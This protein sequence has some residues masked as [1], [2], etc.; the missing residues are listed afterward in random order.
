[1]EEREWG[2][3]DHQDLRGRDA[4]ETESWA[5][6]KK[7]QP[8]VL[9]AP[10]VEA[11]GSNSRAAKTKVEITERLREVKEKKK[12]REERAGTSRF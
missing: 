7:K 12:E 5:T 9:R 4:R 2:G 6:Q 10:Q 3:R 11:A 1:M 8:A